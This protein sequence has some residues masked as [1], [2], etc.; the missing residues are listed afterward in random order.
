MNQTLALIYGG[1]S[2]EHEVSIKTAFSILHAVDYTQ[3]TVMPIYVTMEGEWAQGE[4]LTSKPSDIGAILYKPQA[5]PIN[6]FQLKK[7]V[8]V[9]FPVIH[10]PNGEDGTL[11]GLLEMLDVPYV[12]CGVAASSMGMDKV[13]MKKM[14]EAEGLPQCQYTYYFKHQLETNMDGIVEEIEEKLGYPC[15]VKPANLGSSVGISKAKNRQSLK[16]ALHV[17]ASYDKKV[18]VEENV[19]GRE[20]EIGVLGNDT[21]RTSVIGEVAT[22]SDFYDYEAK[23]QNQQ[24]TSL[25]IPALLPENVQ[26]RVAEIAKKAFHALD[27]TGLARIDFFWVEK[28]DEILINEINTMPGFTPHSMYPMLFKEAGVSYSEL[29]QELVKLANERYAEK[30]QKTI[31]K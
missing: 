23:Y 17:A 10:G 7:E 27:G 22:T 29:I 30:K 14:Y 20:I 25:Q 24:V 16:D 1:K 3:F 15:F 12:G 28:T 4:L 9:I 26:N 8:D 19:V 18:I 31:S 2:G 6:L 13:L 21:L 5:Q 11:Q